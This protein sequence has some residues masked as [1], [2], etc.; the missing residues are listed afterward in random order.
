M[1]DIM[2]K[3]LEQII[4]LKK[5]MN[6]DDNLNNYSIKEYKDELANHTDRCIFLEN[7]LKEKYKII[8]NL[9]NQINEQNEIIATFQKELNEK[10]EK[11]KQLQKDLY[12]K[13]I[14][15]REYETIID[16]KDIII[17]DII[18]NQDYS[19]KALEKKLEE[20]DYLNH[21]K[22]K[23]IS[24]SQK[25]LQTSI[26]LEKDVF[27]IDLIIEELEISLENKLMTVKDF[28][29][30]INNKNETIKLLETKLKYTNNLML[31]LEKE[32]VDK[33]ATIKKTYKNKDS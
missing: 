7:T 18:V 2:M 3:Q 22:Q 6:K 29:T 19:I 15:I 11:I 30:N 14:I 12:D 24:N 5:L 10:E 33:N 26:N 31:D 20:I 32:I 4:T 25:M 16:D 27:D 28:E 8:K 23:F 21:S 17:E 9:E 13:D 1:V